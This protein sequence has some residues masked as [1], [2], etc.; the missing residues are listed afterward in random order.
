M[1]RA[2]NHRSG[3]IFNLNREILPI[4][5]ARRG[6]RYFWNFA[7]SR[8]RHDYFRVT[9]RKEAEFNYATVSEVVAPWDW[10]IAKSE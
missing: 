3:V 9:D 5:G 8:K 10:R 4:H 1:F 7:C 6:K 2:I